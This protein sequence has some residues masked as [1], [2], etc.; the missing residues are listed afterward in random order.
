[1]NDAPYMTIIGLGHT[2]LRLDTGAQQP[3][4]RALYEAAGYAAIP[5][6]NGNPFASFWGEKSL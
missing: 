4:A 1:M 6:Y 2:W 3:G 5:D